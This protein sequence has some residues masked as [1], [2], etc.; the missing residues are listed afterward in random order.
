MRKQLLSARLALTPAERA[1]KSSKIVQTLANEF[2]GWSDVKTIHCF[3]PIE[4]L[5]EVDARPFIELARQQCSAF[6]SRK[7]NGKWQVCPVE[8]NDH[9]P[10]TFDL[11]VVPML[12]FDESLHRLG[13]G[14][15]YYD[16]FLASQPNA[17]KV[18]VCFEIGKVD[19]LPIEPHDIKLERIF[20]E[21]RVYNID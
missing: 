8:G 14:G 2:T 3:E 4:S 10:E 17:Y 13:Y 16:K 15:G 9:V 12:G 7:L 18:G 11:I 20:T 6:T 5:G 1:A 21:R 19:K